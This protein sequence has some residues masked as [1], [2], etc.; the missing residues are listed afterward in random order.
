MPIAE[1]EMERQQFVLAQRIWLVI[2]LYD[3][4]LS[5]NEIYVRQIHAEQTQYAHQDLI[6]AEKIVQY[7]RARQDMLEMLWC[8]AEEENANTTAIAEVT[9]SVILITGVLILARI[10]A[11]L[12][13]NAR[14]ETTSPFVHAH[15]IQAEM[16]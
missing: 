6:E 15:R 16:P 13:P 11:V 7:A 1:Y 9:K 5:K 3:A 8:H 2:R 4:D 10:N 14:W 12:E